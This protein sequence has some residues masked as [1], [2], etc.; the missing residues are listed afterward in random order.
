MISNNLLRELIAFRNERDWKQFHT[1][2]NLASALC[3]EA[4][5]LLDIFRWVKDSEIKATAEQ[6]LN[7]IEDEIADVAILLTYM[8]HDLNISLED[9]VR[10]KIEINRKKYPVEKVKGIS[11]KYNNLG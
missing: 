9:V 11:T 1:T 4:A 7:D 2:R 5:E 8:C 3:V 10:K 6:R